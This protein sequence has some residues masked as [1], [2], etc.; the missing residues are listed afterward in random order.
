M[1]KKLVL[2]QRLNLNAIIMSLITL[3]S[4]SVTVDDV[5]F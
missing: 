2:A 3:I 4:M 1:L 5:N